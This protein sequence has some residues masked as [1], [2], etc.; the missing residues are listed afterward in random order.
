MDLREIGWGYVDWIGQAQDRD[1][2]IALVN[3]VMKLWVAENDGKLS[4]GFTTGSLL[5]NTQLHRVS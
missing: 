5:S 3:S 1:K 2:W 4:S